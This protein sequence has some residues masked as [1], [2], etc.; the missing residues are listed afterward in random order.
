MTRKEYREQLQREQKEKQT[1]EQYK[2]EIED[3]GVIT[4]DELYSLPPSK[5]YAYIKKQQLTD[6]PITVNKNSM[7]DKHKKHYHKENVFKNVAPENGILL[8]IEQ[9]CRLDLLLKFCGVH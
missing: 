6:T 8:F 3:K 1:Q 7:F 4:K 2:Q 5:R 9:A